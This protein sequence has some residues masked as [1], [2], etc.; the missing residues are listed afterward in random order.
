MKEIKAFR[1][2]YCD[3]IYAFRDSCRSHESRCYFNPKT[4]S[5]AS[6]RL[7]QFKDYEYTSGYHVAIRTCLRNY[8]VTRKMKTRCSGYLDKKL[9]ADK[10]MMK[11]IQGQYDP[12]PFIDPILAQMRSDE[13]ES[14]RR[15]KER[16]ELAHTLKAEALIGLLGSAVGYTIL[17]MQEI[18]LT[19]EDTSDD[20]A[21]GRHYEFRQYLVDITISRFQRLGF[22]NERMNQII[23]ELAGKFP[24][25]LMLYAPLCRQ[26]EITYHQKMSEF[27]RLYEDPED[28]S[29]HADIVEKLSSVTTTGLIGQYLF[30]AQAPFAINTPDLNGF[31]VYLNIVEETFPDLKQEIIEGLKNPVYVELSFESPF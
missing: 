13:E 30:S 23:M 28:E 12:N 18:E 15:Q 22:S 16:K 31:S 25:Q 17:L 3:K 21:L 6:C 4:H 11:E 5:C 19:P 2:T 20:E 7:L 14:A 29:Y 8:D 10:A 1:C 9:K 26:G 27:A 24:K